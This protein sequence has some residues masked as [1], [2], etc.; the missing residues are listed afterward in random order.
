MSGGRGTSGS[1]RGGARPEPM[2]VVGENSSSSNGSDAGGVGSCS[3]SGSEGGALV[4]TA[5]L[6][7]GGRRLQGVAG[8]EFARL[9][10]AVLGAAGGGGGRR[11]ECD[12][13]SCAVRPSFR[14]CPCLHRCR[15]IFGRREYGCISRSMHASFAR[16]MQPSWLSLLK[17]A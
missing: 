8:A 7:G 16:V 2:D 14:R 15:H 10:E 9:T 1:T 5:D 3:G 4:S 11:G 6:W 17:N 13:I 12:E